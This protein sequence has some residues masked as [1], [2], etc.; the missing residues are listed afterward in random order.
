MIYLK[1]VWNRS[2]ILF[3]NPAMNGHKFPFPISMGRKVPIAFV[4]VRASPA[5]ASF[6]GGEI[7]L[8]NKAIFLRAGNMVRSVLS[9]TRITK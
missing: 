1:P 2:N 9:L 8:R 3:P 5:P 7:Y 4:I 6:G